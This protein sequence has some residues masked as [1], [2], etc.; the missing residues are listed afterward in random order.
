MTYLSL[1][2]GSESLRC[3]CSLCGILMISGSELSE[4]FFVGI[5]RLNCQCTLMESIV[6]CPH[7]LVTWPS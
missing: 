1:M 5:Q 6:E 4:N 2:I 7:Q 3:I